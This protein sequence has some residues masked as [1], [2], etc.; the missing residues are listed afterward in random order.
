MA[1]K[2]QALGSECPFVSNF[3]PTNEAAT[4]Q[5]FLEHSFLGDL[6]ADPSSAVLESVAGKLQ[7][8]LGLFPSADIIYSLDYDP[9]QPITESQ[10]CEILVRSIA[11]FSAR[12]GCDSE[13]IYYAVFRTLAEKVLLVTGLFHLSIF[14]F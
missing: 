12:K 6:I 11:E 13:G 8:R 7:P 14:Y 9:R 4:I 3:L 5:V 1:E 2:H 10:Y